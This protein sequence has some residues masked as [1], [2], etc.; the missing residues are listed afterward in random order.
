MT[1]VKLLTA[2]HRPLTL[3]SMVN[4]T[5]AELGRVVCLHFGRELE[6][7]RGSKVRMKGLGAIYGAVAEGA[8]WRAA[9]EGAEEGGGGELR[10]LA[11]STREEIRHELSVMTGTL[12]R[13]L[14]L[15][16]QWVRAVDNIFASGTHASMVL[17]LLGDGA[18]PVEA[19]Q[20]RVALGEVIESATSGIALLS[21]EK[22]S[23]VPP[24]VV[25]F[26]DDD[27]ASANARRAWAL[28]GTLE[29]IVAEL[30]K[31]AVG[32][33]IARYGALDVDDAPPIRVAVARD[34]GDGDGD[35][36]DR[37]ALTISD[38]GEGIPREG[39]E[40]LGSAFHT[41][42]VRDEALNEGG[43]ASSGVPFSGSG[44]GTFRSAVF[45]DFIDARLSIASDGGG[46]G[47]TSTLLLR[48][49][50]AKTKS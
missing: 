28:P 31:N 50:S 48:P 19:A 42:F 30:L 46:R 9:I 11:L 49:W 23:V 20:C 10:A 34:G 5:H 2:T 16:R 38:S 4:L 27:D 45:A 22:F 21:R 39:F 18:A 8:A 15:D 17:Q 41:T 7:Q 12:L 6:A 33:T 35:G 13:S 44:F 26:D 37:I 14:P 43:G 1:F 29:F 3:A 36:E 32:S 47:A 40:R 25:E 24:L